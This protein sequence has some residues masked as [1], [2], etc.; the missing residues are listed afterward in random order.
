LGNSRGAKYSFGHINLNYTSSALYWEFSFT[1]MG[2]Y[3]LPAAINYVISNTGKAKI[4]FI[5][6]SQGAS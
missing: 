5:G 4:T 1:D 2:K 3:D 6:H